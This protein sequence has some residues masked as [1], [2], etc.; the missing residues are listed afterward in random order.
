[1]KK[2]KSKFRLSDGEKISRRNFVKVSSIAGLGLFLTSNPR[3]DIAAKPKESDLFGFQ[4]VSTSTEDNFMVPPGYTATP[5]ISWGDPLFKTAPEF[6][7]EGD[8]NADTQAMQFGD[9]NDGM[10][11]F[12]I[13][14]SRALITINHEYANH[15]YLIP[16][17]G[18]FLSSEDVAKSQAAH[19]VSVFEIEKQHDG[20]WKYLRDSK[21]NRRITANTPIDF[22]GPVAGH[23]LLK[24][25]SDPA[26]KRVLGTINNCANGQTPWGTYL[27]C[28]E[29]F[30]YYFAAK[31]RFIPNARQKRYG[32][33][34]RDKRNFQ[35][36]KHDK[37]FD[38]SHYQNESNRFGWVVE[39]DPFKPESIPKKRTA[40]GRF[41]HENAALTIAEGE[42]IVIYMG[43]DQSGEHLY[44]FVS[45]DSFQPEE[46]E[47]NSNLL[48]EGT[49]YVARFDGDIEQLKGTGEW[50]ELTYGK[51]GLTKEN[52]FNSQ[53][54]ILMFAR[55]AATHVGA[56]TMDRPEWVAVHPEKH[57]VYATLTKNKL[58]G[59]VKSQPLNGPNPR[60]AN[61]YGQIVRWWPKNNDHLSRHFDWDLFVLAGNPKIYSGELRAGS[62]NIN[63]DNMFSGPDGIEFDKAG[64][65]W[66][67]T[68]GKDNNSGDFSG[69]GN[70]QVLCAE[71][72][73]GEI[74]RFATGPVGCE[75]TGLAFTPDQRTMFVG[76]QH[77]GGGIETS[78][79]PDGGDSKPRSSIMMIQR[80]DGGIIGN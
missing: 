19:G 65:L 54:E 4:S 37:R 29:N 27:T 43:D 77:P 20:S 12:P 1:M 47:F 38:L 2:E 15:R 31:K 71:P 46:T 13:S 16:F 3:K 62:K 57:S 64:R 26:G 35:W 48:D 40:L 28:E 67:L 78:N 9:N 56:T 30:D 32:L 10:S 68:D 39:I 17:Y 72:N 69:M 22:S 6:D 59:R 75:L 76:V 23:S 18:L 8:Q 36:Y 79:F 66:I 44:K 25:Q 7:P 21:Y 74:R 5:L 42:Q 60:K 53:A 70:N 50:I 61:Q 14:K 58:R 33:D 24:T 49:L 34:A 73:S 41:K 11:L 80:R 52:G 63:A 45:K 51:N 55:L